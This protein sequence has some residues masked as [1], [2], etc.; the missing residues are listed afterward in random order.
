MI[1][2]SPCRFSHINISKYHR[3]LNRICQADVPVLCRILYLFTSG[4]VFLNSDS[5]GRPV[6]K[7]DATLVLQEST[8]CT[9]EVFLLPSHLQ[10]VSDSFQPFLLLLVYL[11]VNEERLILFVIVQQVVTG[12]RRTNIRA[13]PK[14]SAC[15]TGA[16]PCTPFFW[17]PNYVIAAARRKRVS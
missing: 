7:E 2:P 4:L 13:G 15:L 6:R 12:I 8:A 10:C 11:T 9:Y 1:F 5:Y 17:W 3:E 16:P 14:L